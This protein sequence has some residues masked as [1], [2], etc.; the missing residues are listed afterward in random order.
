MNS[1]ERGVSII[2]AS[3]GTGKTYTLCRIVLRL[4]VEKGIPIDR[5]LAITFTQAATN[6]L[7]SRIRELLYDSL[8]Q[9]LSQNVEEPILKDLIVPG[10]IDP[11]IAKCRLRHS[12]EI[13]DDASIS[14]I[15]GF[16]KRSLEFVSLESEI[17]FDANL[18]PV[19]RELIDQFKNEY[20][21]I[22]ILEHSA[23]LTA[24][25]QQKA[26]YSKRL[27]FIAKECVAHPYASLE[28]KPAVNRS[29]ELQSS[30]QNALAALAQ[31]LDE[32][33]SATERLS[34]NSR[35]YKAFA[36]P[37]RRHALIAL[38]ERGY[39]F[40]TDI[41]ILEDFSSIAWR[42]ALKKSEK[43]RS[44][45]EF[46][47][48]FDVLHRLLSNAFDALIASYR[49]WLFKNL[50]EEKERRNVISF[51][52]LLHTLDKALKDS[53]GDGVAQAIANQFD[54]A[55]VDEFQDTDPIQ[56]NIVN[57]L[58][59]NDSH[60]LFFIGDPKQAI[61]RFRG[62]DI[63]AY[64]NATGSHSFGRI[65]LSDNYRSTE[66]LVG[67]VNALFE[68]S[69]DG[70]AFDRIQFSPATAV[71]REGPSAPLRINALGLLDSERLVDG[72]ATRSLAR[73]AAKDLANRVAADPELDLSS[74][75]F[76]V[77][78]N[79]EAD[80]LLDSLSQQGIDA[81]I[82]SERSIFKTP[83][84][85][86][87]LQL[88]NTLSNPSRRSSL[89]ALLLT[90][91]G[92]YSWKELQSESF[93]KKT[94]SVAAFIHEWAHSWF[95]TKFDA[96]FHELLK[97]TGADQQ[98]LRQRD[99]ERPY[100]NLLQ[101]S[102]LLQMESLHS[103][104]T[105]SRLAHWLTS[106]RESDVTMNEEW[107]TRLIS[108]SGK[109]QIVTI[110]KSKGLQYPIV[111]CPFLSLLRTRPKRDFA[112]YHATDRDDALVIDL[113]PEGKQSALDSAESEEY[114]E[115]LRLIYVALT[116]AVDECSLYL[117]PEE[118]ATRQKRNPSSFCRL[119]M[120][121]DRSKRLLEDRELSETFVTRIEEFD[122]NLISLEPRSL[123]EPNEESAQELRPREAIAVSEVKALLVPNGKIPHSERILS[124]STI[125]RLAHS[126]D[127]FNE[128]EEIRDDENVIEANELN[129]VPAESVEPSGPSIF[130]LPKGAHTGNL[131]HLILEEVDFQ[132]TRNLYET[133][134]DCFN[135]L[136]YGFSE[137]KGVVCDHVRMLID[138]EIGKGLSLSSIHHNERIPEL[139][140]A[141]PT[142]HDA[143][144]KMA[145]AFQSAN[146]PGIPQ[147]WIHSLSLEETRVK[148]SML[149]G[150]IDLVFERDDKLYIADWKSNYLGP[151]ASSYSRGA[152]AQAM[153]QHDY[154][155]QYCLY[156]VALLRYIESRFP[157]EDPYD[158]FGGVFYIF[159]RGI[160]STG[161]N[162][163]FFD[164]PSKSLI[165]ALDMALKR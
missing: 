59:G 74:V 101:L 88:L 152:L 104:A 3:A 32:A 38:I 147:E 161:D 105:P 85:Q 37:E 35:Q 5:I 97:L 119:I 84:A 140:F 63:Y 53:T 146:S 165:Q 34:K 127:A 92:G 44:I 25:Y 98:L 2:E 96:G 108:E 130:T 30:Y 124:F 33:E 13:F 14:T 163:I 62:A 68:S 144:K 135:R 149:R 72:I 12:L 115:H 58:F 86:S 89:H 28:P 137:F 21:R 157:S 148:A 83:E 39:P 70:F 73:T 107:Q 156:S 41:P 141:Y 69:P 125:T 93:E 139:E 7:K 43:E 19:D 4:V 16:C 87:M 133:V 17:P 31:F 118:S 57:R 95:E 11:E 129:Q 18:E 158:R 94:Q 29:E 123:E 1:L 111:V 112:L 54:A 100:S 136:R 26:I 99:G 117:V 36:T 154:Y 78:R 151:D 116:R 23:L 45:P 76:L 153:A 159:I 150:F 55:L 71:R 56:F 50:R 128:V 90:P 10:G 145:H 52:D 49:E 113:S 160:E 102:E 20:I 82:K 114:A 164:R 48:H 80:I 132:D 109:P 64:F 47:D 126:M 61:Y 138:R 42:K 77:S 81:V 134:S 110:H 46:L 120:G 121:S 122:S 103:L 91:I 8:H 9:V 79:S 75:A 6:E 67:A 51:N 143:L 40:A 60:Y 155:L 66:S 24:F 131:I 162:G 15:H 65:L 142:S 22:H 27:D 106:N